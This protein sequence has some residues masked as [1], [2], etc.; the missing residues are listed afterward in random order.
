MIICICEG[1]NDKTISKEI[2]RG[3][4]SVRAIRRRCGAG[5]GCGQCVA[6][7]K[8][9]LQTGADDVP[10]TRCAPAEAMLAS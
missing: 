2:Q 3:A 10:H 8:Q 6:D 7:L 1:V 4:S 9:M 5:G